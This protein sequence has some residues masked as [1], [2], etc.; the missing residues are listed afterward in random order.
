MKAAILSDNWRIFRHLSVLRVWNLFLLRCS[1]SLSRLLGR[2]VLLGKPYAVSIE[3]TTACNLSCPACPSGLKQFSRATGKLSVGD[4][5]DWLNKLGKQ[6]F[7][8]NYYFQ[9]EP[10]LNPQFL[11]LVGEAKK[12]KIYTSTS[13]NAHF[14]D[15][16]KAKEIVD[17]GLDRLIISIDGLTQE[18]YSSYRVDGKLEKVL[19]A[20]R[21]LVEAKKEKASCTP[22][23]IF[24][25]LVVSTNEHEIQSLQELASEIGVDEVRFKTAQLYDFEKDAYLIPENEEYSRYVRRA[26]GSYRLKYKGG[27]SCWRMWSSAVITW[28]G[29][30]VPCCFDKDAHYQLGDI[31]NSQLP[32]IWNSQEYKSFRRQILTGRNEVDMC[33]N[34]SEGA[35][36]WAE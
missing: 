11:E 1:F 22:H 8:I 29:K 23:L 20:S 10:F 26:D 18:T 25:F 36:V 2:P 24:Q 31:R 30:M 13:T 5:R 27:N 12:R 9:G 7:Y 3:P 28:D 15:K 14:I 35:K 19:K 34:C 6:L 21:C 16:Q 33:T 32:D 17:S 4:N